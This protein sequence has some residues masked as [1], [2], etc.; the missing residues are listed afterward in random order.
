[1][2]VTAVAAVTSRV[3]AASRAHFTPAAAVVTF[4][5]LLLPFRRIS[6]TLRR[7]IA[8]ARYR[9][10]YRCHNT[11]SVPI[12]VTLGLNIFT[13]TFMLYTAP[14]LLCT[15]RH[16]HTMDIPLLGSLHTVF[17]CALAMPWPRTRAWNSDLSRSNVAHLNTHAA[18]QIPDDLVASIS[19]QRQ[20]GRPW[21]RANT[22]TTS[23]PPW[24]SWTFTPNT[25][26]CAATAPRPRHLYHRAFHSPFSVN[27]PRCTAL[28]RCI[29]RYCTFFCTTRCHTSLPRCPD[30]R[31][32]PTTPTCFTTPAAS[33][34]LRRHTRVPPWSWGV[35]R[36]HIRVSGPVSGLSRTPDIIHGSYTRRTVTANGLS[37]GD[38]AMPKQ[39]LF[40]LMTL[41]P[42]QR[43]PFSRN[44]A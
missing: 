9:G 14:H 1:M 41:L 33:S 30:Y 19:L 39:P 7:S 11:R 22:A 2:G 6:A 15:Y 8:I 5:T 28:H 31:A 20:A 32:C 21:R 27:T 42:S 35:G 13:F 38:A 34:G 4:S 44:D 25:S 37:R 36:S 26:V 43:L 18:R 24:R 17:F 12:C 10:C 23:L 40:A 3:F 16:L 29:A